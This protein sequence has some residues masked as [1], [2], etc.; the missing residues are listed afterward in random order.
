M[1]GFELSQINPAHFPWSGVVRSVAVHPHDP[2]TL[3]IGTQGGGLFL[4]IDGGLHWGHLDNFEPLSVQMISYC[5]SDPD[6]MLAATGFDTRARRSGGIWRSIDGGSTWV[7][8]EGSIP[9]IT[10]RWPERVG[11]NALSWVPGSNTVWVAADYGLMR[12]DDRGE[13]WSGPIMIDPTGVSFADVWDSRFM[14]DR[15]FSVLAV[16]EHSVITG[17]AS[18]HYYMHDGITWNRSSGA[19]NAYGIRGLAAAPGNPRLLFRVDFTTAYLQYS[20]NQGISWAN[21]PQTGLEG[22][23]AGPFV[24]T[25][26]S[27]RGY[28]YFELYYGDG[29]HLKR[30]TLS[31][32]DLSDWRDPART[33]WETATLPHADPLDIA[34]HPV[35]GRPLL[36]V[37]DF[38][39][40]R[41]SDD[42]ATWMMV[43]TGAN[44][45]NTLDIFG[46]GVQRV[47]G[48]TGQTDISLVTWHNDSWY[49]GDHGRSWERRAPV[50][51]WT[52]RVS[53][54]ELASADEALVSVM[55]YGGTSSLNTRG[56][57][58]PV[59]A[60]PPRNDACVRH[61]V[62]YTN[63]TDSQPYVLT[64]TYG[65]EG[66]SV[67]Y[68]QRD[69]RA[70][71]W[72]EVIRGSRSMYGLPQIAVRAGRGFLYHT[73][74]DNSTE[75]RV[76]CKVTNINRAG[77]GA[78][79]VSTPPMRGFGSIGARRYGMD[80]APVFAVR[81]DDERV[82]IAVDEVS[83]QMKMSNNGG[84]TWQLMDQ[85]SRLVVADGA[86]RFSTVDNR[87]QVTTIAFDPYRTHRVI[88]GTLQAGLFVSVTGGETWEKIPGSEAV[89][90]VYEIAYD[91][92][93]TAYIATLGRGLW[94]WAFSLIHLPLDV[95]P[96]L[97]NAIRDPVTGVIVPMECLANPECCPACLQ[98]IAQR[99][100]IRNIEIAPE[101]KM[102]TV[103]ATDPDA[104][105]T[106]SA[107]S[108]ELAITVVPAKEDE[109]PKSWPAWAKDVAAGK[110]AK[111][112]A[113]SGTKL[114]GYIAAARSKWNIPNRVLFARESLPVF[115]PA[116]VLEGVSRAAGYDLAVQGSKI[117]VNGSGFVST[118]A[119]GKDQG[120]VSLYLNGQPVNTEIAV[121]AQGAFN[122]PLQL[123]TIP[124][125][126]SVLCTQESP[127]GRLVV[128]RHLLILN[129]DDPKDQPM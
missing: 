125:N 108:I 76:L 105:L 110:E 51:G 89:T 57:R 5:P 28:P 15:L 94:K 2:D 84:A 48:V 60:F 106:Y 42:G 37:G 6:I 23:N 123:K 10:A 128:E 32:V 63:P 93:G 9:P 27:Q 116:V 52:I 33:T 92:N 12:S 44:G 83:S 46:L 22:G 54:P 73:F 14:P 66:A 45:L 109:T 74:V 55:P 104:I 50:E 25:T 1:P 124:G 107:E 72:Q 120:K 81:P 114:L 19:P 29:T 91:R 75:R 103:Y 49:S 102:L 96:W 126:G 36:L 24:K 71:T 115:T 31:A 8:P 77:G 26:T 70:A 17:G 64:A 113:L 67:I 11:A 40:M 20:K 119:S 121:D 4:S 13:H 47:G 38:G 80:F 69:V 97:N 62:F 129:H 95:Y 34:F 127:F 118:A 86:L 65:C 59:S 98:I 56:L 7:M 99:G 61:V 30:V 79:L 43:G 35:T 41:T 117:V 101:S 90:Q 78:P 21:F 16:D 3:C 68:D 82:L 88:V 85:L 39:A 122:I 18:G 111:V 112:I 53:G 100:Y 87:L 58:E